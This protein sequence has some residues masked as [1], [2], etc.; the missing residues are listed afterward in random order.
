MKTLRR[1]WQGLALGAAVQSLVLADDT[2]PAL[3]LTS[4]AGK[5]DALAVSGQFSRAV[6]G[7]LRYA[8]RA[9]LLAL[10]GVTRLRERPWVMM[11]EADLTVV[12]LATVVGA[13]VPQGDADA[14]LLRC[15]D[16]WESVLPLSFL[17]SH[18]PYLLLLHNGKSPEQ[19]WP[20]FSRVEGLAPYYVNVSEKA[21]PGFKGVID[22]GMISATQVVEIRAINLQRHFAPLYAGTWEKLSEEASA[23]RAIFVRHCNNC[24]Q[25]QGVGGNTSQRPL[26]LL[27]THATHNPQFFRTMVTQ[28]KSVYPD[29]VMPPHPFDDVTFIRLIQFLRETLALSQTAP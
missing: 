23:G 16:R 29:T 7:E 17:A 15:S 2:I 19:G 6:P 11:P 14:I 13:L 20:M 4:D 8:D 24:H 5:G 28:P 26:V 3:V 27:Q 25:A 10:P 12:P 1:L 18:Q 9:S 21:H 22:T